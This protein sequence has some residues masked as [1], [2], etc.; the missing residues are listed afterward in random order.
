MPRPVAG[1]CGIQG[2]GGPADSKTLQGIEG[3]RGGRGDTPRI[4]PGVPKRVGPGS[5]LVGLSQS[6]VMI[7]VGGFVKASRER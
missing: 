6:V 3:T 1:S 4:G 5:V 7:N 2:L